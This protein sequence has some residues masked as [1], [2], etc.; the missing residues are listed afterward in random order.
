MRS[1]GRA[2]LP[3]GT[4]PGG[5][6]STT[7]VSP[8]LSIARTEHPNAA[9][10]RESF[11][12]FDRGDL[13]SVRAH[14]ADDCVWTNYG[15]SPLA[16]AHR[17]WEAIEA[18]FVQLFTLTEG[19]FTT[20]LTAVLADDQRAVGLYEA[21]MTLGGQTTTLP[22]VIVDRVGPDGRVLTA[23][24]ICYDQAAADALL[25]GIPQQR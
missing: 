20:S 12:A 8:D 24:C 21:T 16:G 4:E 7:H 17:G 23:D 2:D 13:A 9:R 18:M 10:M 14:L 3:H 15:S 6:M 5:N 1:R 19:T 22:W 25:G 11:A